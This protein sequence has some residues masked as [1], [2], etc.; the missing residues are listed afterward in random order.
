MH[1]YLSN[2]HKY[3]SNLWEHS[4]NCCYSYIFVYLPYQI[5]IK[6][7]VILMYYAF[8]QYIVDTRDIAFFRYTYG[9]SYYI[10]DSLRNS[11]IF[12]IVEQ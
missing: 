11:V 1:V 12:E 2:K 5:S 9:I 6:F 10:L 3:K 8:A 7:H 4:M